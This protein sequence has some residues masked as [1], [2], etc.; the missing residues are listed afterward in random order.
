MKILILCAG[1]G[2]RWGNSLNTKKHLVKINN[3]PLLVRTIE[4]IKSLNYSDISIIK[5]KGV[6]DYDFLPVKKIDISKTKE[7]GDIDKI[8]SSRDHW[9]KTERTILILGDVYFTDQAIKTILNHS[10]RDW[11]QFG[12]LGHSNLPDRKWKGNE[13]FGFSFFPEHIEKIKKSCWESINLKKKGLIRRNRMAQFYR[14]MCGKEGYNADKRGQPQENLGN[15][16]EI[17]DMTDDIDYFEDALALWKYLNSIEL[18]IYEQEIKY[19]LSKKKM[20]VR[21]SIK[22]AKEHFKK[23]IVAVEIGVYKGEN[24][25]NILKNLKVEKLYLI[26]PFELYDDPTSKMGKDTEFLKVESIAKETLKDYEDKIVWIKKK[27]KEAIEDI[28]LADFIY[29]DGNH[30][31]NYIKEDMALYWNK[32]KDKGILA[33]HDITSKEGVKKAFKEFSLNKTCKTFKDDW[34]VYK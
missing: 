7:I 23:D 2:L 19:Y 14:I 10:P 18:K 31:Y 16:I 11:F 8:F 6:T 25:L 24:A 28:P 3:K 26:D 20:K 21:N 29:I 30:E 4:Q 5:N 22:I 13:N 9:S 34:V 27:S 17:N 1:G 32:I 12:R 15:F 33:G